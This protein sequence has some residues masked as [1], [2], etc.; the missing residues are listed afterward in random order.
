MRNSNTNRDNSREKEMN[1]KLYVSIQ[2]EKNF[3]K[4]FILNKYGIKEDDITAWT[5][6]EIYMD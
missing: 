2:G 5:K 4:E 6:L 3:I 1:S